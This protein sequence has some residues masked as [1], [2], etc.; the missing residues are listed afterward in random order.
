MSYSTLTIGNSSADS[1]DAYGVWSVMSQLFR[2]FQ[3]WASSSL[4]RKRGSKQKKR[5]MKRQ[6]R[7]LLNGQF[8]AQPASAVVNHDQPAKSVQPKDFDATIIVNPDQPAKSV[9]PKDFDATIIVN[10]DQPAKSVQL[11]DLD[12]TIIVNPDQPA[13]LDAHSDM[14]G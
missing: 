8:H 13:E 12:A 6:R 2:P 10:P 5:Q 1:P 7:H 14:L 4:P 3:R 9:Q 11:M